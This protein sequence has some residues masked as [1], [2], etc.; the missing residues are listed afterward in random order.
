MYYASSKAFYKYK[1]FKQVEK[2]LTIT[3]DEINKKNHLIDSILNSSR[4]HTKE[5]KQKAVS[6]DTKLKQDEKNID[7]TVVSD[8]ALNEF[9]TKHSN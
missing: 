3:K 6:I 5:V 2:E 8:D 7:D 1:Y 9:I 4:K